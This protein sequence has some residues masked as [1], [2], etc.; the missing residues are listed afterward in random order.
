[1]STRYG[2]FDS[3]AGDRIYSSADWA[4]I[5]KSF[6]KDG[7]VMGY[8]GEMYV[9]PASPAA[10]SV[11]VSLGAAFIQGRY[12][13]VYTSEETV[14]L[15]AAHATLARI[16]RIVLRLDYTAR[17]IALAAL[18]GTAAVT[19]VAPALTQ[20]GSTWEIELAQVAVAALA[21]SITAANIA[22]KINERAMVMNVEMLASTILSGDNVPIGA[23]RIGTAG[24]SFATVTTEP[25]GRWQ[26]TATGASDYSLIRSHSTHFNAL[27]NPKLATRCRFPTGSGVANFHGFGLTS[28][29]GAGLAALSSMVDDGAI[30]YNAGTGSWI[31]RTMDGTAATATT[32]GARDTVMRSWEIRT[33]DNGVTWE[34]VRDGEV[35]ASHT[36]NVPRAST[37]VMMYGCGFV[38]NVGTGAGDASPVFDYIRVDQDRV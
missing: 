24:G 18:T 10:M 12:F 4:A 8:Q 15:A 38:A 1:M 25:N 2:F 34:C 9:K 29:S 30:L 33:R 17:T 22:N 28:N 16:D 26:L 27:Y 3:V 6:L 14:A 36:T 5:H 23:N 32:I 37:S 21:T 35:V 11:K 31:F 20:T 7:P 13:E 19:P